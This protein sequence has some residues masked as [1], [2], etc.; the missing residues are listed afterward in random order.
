M[1]DEFGGTVIDAPDANSPSAPA[2]QSRDEFGGNILGSTPSTPAPSNPTQ[3]F[4]NYGSTQQAA[5]AYVRQKWESF[6]EIAKH[7]EGQGIE[8]YARRVFGESAPDRG[9]EAAVGYLQSSVGPQRAS[10][11]E[12]Q[13]RQEYL[14]N[15]LGGAV[16]QQTAAA[17]APAPEQVSGIKGVRNAVVRGATKVITEP[18][19]AGTNLVEG[20]VE[21]LNT[22]EDR[23]NGTQ[24][25]SQDTSG[26][27]G[28]AAGPVD[29]YALARLSSNIALNK[30][31]GNINTALPQ[32][33]AAQQ[34]PNGVQAITENVAEMLPQLALTGKAFAAGGFQ[35]ALALGQFGASGFDQ[36]YQSIYNS[37]KAQGMNEADANAAAM[38]GGLVD[39]V[40][41]T[42]LMKF[43]AIGQAAKANPMLRRMITLSVKDALAQG[44]VGGS[45]ALIGEATKYVTT[46]EAPQVEAIINN[47]IQ[48]AGAGAAFGAGR[49]AIEGGHATPT[50]EAPQ[51]QPVPT[52]QAPTT[53]APEATG[54]PVP[55]PDTNTL[56]TLTEQQP[57]APPVEQAKPAK[58]LD[59]HTPKY[60]VQDGSESRGVPIEFESPDDKAL[61]V[62]TQPRKG[63]LQI[64]AN[65]YLSEKGFTDAAIEEKG[66][67]L[68]DRIDTL[69]S[70]GV[71]DRL[72]VPA[73]RRPVV[74]PETVANPEGG[75][76]SVP[77]SQLSALPEDISRT[78]A[79]AQPEAE[80]AVD[81]A[82]E[83]QPVPVASDAVSR[84]VDDLKN[85]RPE[86]KVV[87]PGK[88]VRA[89]A[90]AAEKIL[91]VNVVHINDAGGAAGF[92]HP[93]HP[94]VVFIDARRPIQGW[95]S[96][97][98]H[99]WLHTVQDTDPDAANKFYNAIPAEKRQQYIDQYKSRLEHLQGV[100][101]LKYL[102]PSNVKREVGAMAMTDAATRGRVRREILGQ[103]P[104]LWDRIT[105]P[106]SKIADKLTGKSEIIDKAIELIQEKRNENTGKTGVESNGDRGAVGTTDGG[107]SGGSRRHIPEV[108]SASYLPEHSERVRDEA[109]EYTKL[110][111]LPYEPDHTYAKVDEA[112]ATKIA[113]DYDAAT[114]NPNDPKVK[115]S[116][117]AMKR[118]TLDQWNF[119]Q[120]KGVKFEAWKGEG[121]PYKDSAAM[122]RDVRDNKHLYF[123]TGGDMPA[124]HPLAEKAPGTPYTYNDVF[125]AVHDYFGH[126]KEGVGFGPRG[127]ENAWR[128]HSQMYSEEARPAMTAETRMQNSWVNFGPHGE[129]NRANPQNTKYAEQKATLAPSEYTRVERDNGTSFYPG[130]P[131][132][133]EDVKPAI[134]RLSEIGRDLATGVKR[135]LAPQ[136]RGVQAR[137]A[138]GVLR[139]HGA[140]L[141]QRWD[142][143]TAAFK[144]AKSYMD[145]LPVAA[146][147]SFIDAMERGQK[148]ADAKLQPLADSLR[149]VLDDRLKQVQGL[150]TG[151]LTQFVKDYFPHLWKDPT[152]ASTIFQ[153]L[154]AKAP[155]QGK[156]S[157]LKARSLP[158][159]SDGIAK[160]LEPVTENP[161]EATMLRVREMDK[162][163]T[164]QRA[165]QEMRSNG[166]MKKIAARDTA[167]AT[168]YEKIDDSI[169]TIFAPP[170]RRGG[171]SIAGYWMAPEPVA[172]VI[173]NYLSPG[174]R[175]NKNVGSAFRGFL[176]AGN[177]MNQAQLGLSAF[178]LMM[179][180]LDSATSKMSLSFKQLGAGKVS[181]AGKSLLSA[182]SVFG[183][184]IQNIHN[185]NL[186]LR[187]WMKPGSTTPEIAQ[188]VDAMKAAGGRAKMDDFYHTGM[189]DK[190]MEAFRKGNTLG[191][192][193]RAPMAAM[194]Q[195]SKP[196][197]EQIVPRMKMGVF[198][199]LA[200]FEL[201]KLGTS[202]TRDELREAMGRAWDS[203][204]NR[205]GELVYD[206]LFWN[207]AAKDLAMASTR[208]VGWNLGTIRELGGGVY[209]LVKNAVIAGKD[210]SF[211]NTE[212]THRMAYTAAMPVMAGMVG[213]ML[214]YAL[215]NGVPQ[216]AKDWFFPKTGE[217]D[218][219]GHDV[220]L[221]LP[222]YMK[223][224][225]E[226]AKDAKDAYR[227]GDLTKLGHTI[228][229]K[230]HPL[231]N[232]VWDMLKN[233]DYYGNKI[234]NEDDPFVRK[235][236]DE[237]K[238]V[239]KQ[240]EPFGVR[241]AISLA[242]Q[243]QG[244]KSALPLIGVNKARHD[245]INSPAEN[246]ARDLASDHQ[247]VGSRTQAQVEHSKTVRDL[248]DSLHNK[249]PDARE[250]IRAAL[251]DGT[252]EEGD[253]NT[254]RASMKAP[255]QL[256]R[257]VRHLGVHD[258][259]KVWDTA[260]DGERKRLGNIIAT[261]IRSS[262]DVSR[263]ERVALMQRFQSDW[264][265]LKAGQTPEGEE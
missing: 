227:T 181:E 94:N 161:V 216:T 97:L 245:I 123:F 169:A 62:A 16:N 151:K 164:A 210:R 203:V 121:Q 61:Y 1:R 93:A 112:R 114:H 96:V 158:F 92:T 224:V 223:D 35:K 100:D 132:V 70:A 30:I 226:Y 262:K 125:R 86:A 85:I 215:G 201:G 101:K 43:G 197:M 231:V 220:R 68:R 55:V 39:A 7:S 9:T 219:E 48:G 75:R 46:G 265:A 165:F 64:E 236:V 118:E 3:K 168:G 17:N 80:T 207:K 221:A 142:R 198:M 107:N 160:G 119:L 252:I 53:P 177:V 49:G 109:A 159:M 120:K 167:K 124:D 2:G 232:A 209:D 149:A 81:H 194:E 217:K 143:L 90:T 234:R 180:T 72:A 150:G 186:I 76:S 173:N 22:L 10:Q 91:G 65:K 58:S 33:T 82:T 162:Y 191:G 52:G 184:A 137:S 20:G 230:T 182:A 108:E 240:F 84:A 105:D 190:M 15:A 147:R 103:D 89:A 259:M 34:N 133:E 233:E 260:D 251:K 78:S 263:D 228:S 195:L 256:E 258:A 47:A 202:A 188:V 235:L 185:G 117:D 129:E 205:M 247:P 134:E 44:A 54:S 77:D 213:G 139:E 115:E 222:S 59:N 144:D 175:G 253:L 8:D 163:I 71:A 27:H 242:G 73:E 214:H 32:S 66:Q 57:P 154:A 25:P 264:K 26:L 23:V 225:L 18:V 237:A 206:N 193:L 172:N 122:L 179:T 174:L 79:E 261:K 131:F 187:E 95:A 156:K 176:A 140:E 5:D 152:K 155:L 110:H 28:A 83:G 60:R 211:K 189:T 249:E 102:N 36:S 145:K 98:A 88:V 229:N 250:R 4:Q 135:I 74:Q 14:N 141:A 41:N 99:E 246:L 113:K 239:G 257:S 199:D 19:R 50:P 148:Q 31:T 238:F 51:Q 254:I 157:F 11:L 12:A 204:D 212:F 208:S 87:T 241:E 170:N 69:A 178:H 29:P 171:L 192:V 127:E 138:A 166:L 67:Q 153:E 6:G 218:K 255:G 40:A 45:Q 183:P 126:A 146:T 128:A 24:D 136:T 243:G 21:F 111:N 116:Y 104:K 63:K 130:K 200:K 37:A 244:A 42:Y 38:G 13:W 56:K 248:A 106:F 196:L